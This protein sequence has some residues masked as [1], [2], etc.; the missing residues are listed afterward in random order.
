MAPPG[1]ERLLQALPGAAAGSFLTLAFPDEGVEL[2]G[3]T[4]DRTWNSEATASSCLPSSQPPLR[5]LKAI[6]DKY[7]Q[8]KLLTGVPG[9]KSKLVCPEYQMQKLEGTKTMA[10]WQK[11]WSQ[12]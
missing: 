3:P 4:W 2:R 6:A 10:I 8:I 1:A 12:T 11:S 9:E 5:R 7:D